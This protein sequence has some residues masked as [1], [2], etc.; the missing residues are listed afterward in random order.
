MAGYG[1]VAEG[2]IQSEG[3]MDDPLT[4]SSLLA[5][6]PT[7]EKTSLLAAGAGSTR[8]H[9]PVAAEGGKG[10]GE[11][12]GEEGGE[13]EIEKSDQHKN[14]DFQLIAVPDSRVSVAS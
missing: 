9:S 3:G 1:A 2:Y 8:V 14:K 5:S 6:T 4:S 10:E 12:Q 7:D 11:G 13:A